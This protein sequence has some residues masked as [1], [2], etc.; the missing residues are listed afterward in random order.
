ML[1]LYEY[2]HTYASN[3]MFSQTFIKIFSSLITFTCFRCIYYNYLSSMQ[4][5]LTN[6]IIS[7]KHRSVVYI[8]MY[9]KKS[10]FIIILFIINKLQMFISNSIFLWIQLR[11]YYV[12]I[13]VYLNF[14]HKCS[15]IIILSWQWTLP[16]HMI[17]IRYHSTE[18]FL[19]TRQSINNFFAGKK[20]EIIY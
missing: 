11:K 19:A 5:S 3:P 9:K 10:I 14:S 18:N 15:L 16:I 8:Q 12:Y 1:L 17:Y 6:I 2:I 7:L 4:A 20:I 13:F